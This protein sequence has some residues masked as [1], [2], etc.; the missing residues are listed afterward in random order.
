MASNIHIKH[1]T[2]NTMLDDLNTAIGSSGLLKIYTGTQPAGPDTGLSG[3]TLLA[4]LALSSSAFAS[5]S[6]GVLT[7]NTISDDTNAAATGTATWATFTTSG[8]TRIM[9]ISVGTSGADLNLNTTAIQAGARVSVTS[10]T[11]TIA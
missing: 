4:T 7:A 1:S 6:S 8:G 11:L 3:N 2:A 9:D 10:Y 5:A